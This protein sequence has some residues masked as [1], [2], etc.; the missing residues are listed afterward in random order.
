MM[1]SFRIFLSD[2]YAINQEK[3]LIRHRTFSFMFR[4]FWPRIFMFCFVSDTEKLNYM[5]K[6]EIGGRIRIRGQMTSEFN[7]MFF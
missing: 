1:A 2:F 6:T 4:L 7:F 5:L 3:K